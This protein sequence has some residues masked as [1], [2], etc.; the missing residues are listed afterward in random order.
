MTLSGHLS[1]FPLLY[2]L[3]A[4]VFGL[5][6]TPAAFATPVGAPLPGPSGL[7]VIP[8]TQTVVGGQIA[9]SLG[10]EYVNIS[11]ADGHASLLPSAN[12]SYS[13]NKGEVGVAY[14]RQKT[15]I[16][17]FSSSNSYFALHGKYRFML[18]AVTS[19]SIVKSAPWG[20][21]RSAQ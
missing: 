3:V 17:G 11:G 6:P 8:T 18:L 5:L 14:L 19:S 1:Q 16:E 21:C 7:G 10:Y 4:V 13:F 12:L 20:V 2:S 15:A 9:A